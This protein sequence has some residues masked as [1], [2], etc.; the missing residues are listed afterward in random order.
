LAKTTLGFPPGEARTPTAPA[1]LQF[2]PEADGDSPLPK[3][4]GGTGRNL[5]RWPVKPLL[6]TINVRPP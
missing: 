6:I 4:A 1:V 5:G 3:L 2:L